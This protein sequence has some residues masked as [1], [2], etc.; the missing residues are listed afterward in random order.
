[1]LGNL[2][3]LIAVLHLELHKRLVLVVGPVPLA[4]VGSQVVVIALAALL[5]SSLDVD[6]RG[7]LSP[8]NP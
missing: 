8:R 1:M 5:A 2:G 3:P 7:Y 4:D 6:L